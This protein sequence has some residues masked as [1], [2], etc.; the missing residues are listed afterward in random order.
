MKAVK[1]SFDC[2][3]DG[4]AN[5]ESVRAAETRRAELEEARLFGVE[6]GIALGR[7]QALAET[8]AHIAATVDGLVLRVS[9]ALARLDAVAAGIRRDAVE[10]AVLTARMLGAGAMARFP[11]ESIAELARGVIEQHMQA[12]RLVV[13]V[14]EADLEAIKGRLEGHASAIGFQGRMIFLGEASVT[15]GD[16]LVEWADGGV[17]HRLADRSAAIE[18]AVQSYMASNA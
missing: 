13:R 4:G 18:S 1:F 16:C 12:S 3:F 9:D 15:R 8:E 10:L 11:D 2:S 14:A 6:S 7:E 5:D 17:E